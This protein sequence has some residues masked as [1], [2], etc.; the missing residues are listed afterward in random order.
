M[1]QPVV[2]FEII[3][4]GRGEAAQLLRRAVRLEDRRRQPDELRAW[5]TKRT[6]RRPTAAS[7]SAAASPA[8]RRSRD[9]VTFYVAVP[10]VEEALVKAESLG[11]TRVMGPQKVNDE[12]ELGQFKDPERQRDRPGQG[13]QLTLRSP[14][15]CKQ[16]SFSLCWA[17]LARA[18]P[19]PLRPARPDRDPHPRRARRPARQLDSPARPRLLLAR[20]RHRRLPR[21]GPRR[22]P[23]LRRAARR[24]RRRRGLHR[25]QL[26]ASAA[27]GTRAA[28]ASSRSSSSPA[29]PPG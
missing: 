24:L 13:R 9:S 3:G 14:S 26:G 2:H 19:A 25:R 5:S 28:T 15:Y 27:A 21:P 6:T 18:L 4:T 11:G 1:G 22:R 16:D 23:R 20:G 8:T 7:G 10:D 12:V 29:S 17:R